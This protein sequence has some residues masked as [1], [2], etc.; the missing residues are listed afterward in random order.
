M[1]SFL[2]QISSS[3][4]IKIPV[5]LWDWLL[6]CL[7]GGILVYLL[8]QYYSEF[9]VVEKNPLNWL[10]YIFLTLICSSLF[11]VEIFPFNIHVFPN[12]AQGG[13]DFYFII[14][15]AIPWMATA[16]F[17]KRIL[18]ISLATL[19][20]LIFSGF[21]EH[22]IFYILLMISIALL[23]NHMMASNSTQF[24]RYNSHPLIML[25]LM[26][27]ITFPLFFGERFAEGSA[28]ELA[29]R[30]D[31]S[32]HTGWVFYISRISELF[33][34]GFFSEYLHR[35]QTS[36]RNIESKI[37][38]KSTTKTMFMHMLGLFYLTLFV[39]TILWNVTRVSSLSKWKT[40]MSN[41]IENINMAV[42]SVFTSNAVRIDQLP[43]DVVLG[44]GYIEQRE[45]VSPIFQPV[46]NLDAFYI[47][48]TQGEL[49]FAYPL[50]KE[51]DM[52]I[53]DGE[54]VAFQNSVQNDSIEGAFSTTLDGSAFDISIIYPVHG[55]SEDI[56]RVVI[57]RMD[58]KNNPTFLALATLLDTTQSNGVQTTF[59]NAMAN[60]R[61][62]WNPSA[63]GKNNVAVV[64]TPMGLENWGLEL[65]LDRSA[66]LEDFFQSF[67][68]FF[69]GTIV[70]VLLVGGYYLLRWIKLE[71][72][73]AVL[74]DR[75]SHD[76]AN[77]GH[78]SSREALPTSLQRF[79]TI[80]KEVFQRLDKRYQET[81][82]YLEL[83]GSY[84][85]PEL[86]KGMVEQA[87]QPFIQEDM[88][89]IKVTIENQFSS[90]S[91]R[92]YTATQ[93]EECQ[94]YDYL[95]EQILNVIEGQ[96][97]LVIGN[98]ARFHQLN[99][100][101]GKPFPQALIIS[102]FPMDAQR[103][104]VLWAAF[105]STQEFSQEFIH[106]F[107]GKLK[108][109]SH[110]LIEI[111]KLQQWL[112][113]KNILSQLFDELNFPLFIFV[114]QKLIYGN[115]AGEAFLKID[116][117]ES[118]TSIAKRVQ[119]NEIYNLLERNL[120]QA[121]AILTKNMPGGEKYEIEIFNNANPHIGQISVL[122][123]KDITQVKRREEMTRDF[124]TMLSHGLR[125]PITIMQGYSKM[126]PMVGELNPPQQDYLD[127]I[128]NGLEIITSLVE[129]ILLEDR[130]ENG[131]EISSE[132]VN[133]KQMIQAVINQLESF[134]TQKRVKVQVIDI[135]PGLTL[136]GDKILLNQAFSNLLH[137]AIK[138]SDMEGM[139][140]I[141]AVQE[142]DGTSITIKD[143]GPGIA[144]IDI[145]FI[146]EKYY[147]Q[148]GHGED[149][150]KT[151]GMGL[152]I[153]KFIIDAHR[154]NIS[155]ESELGKGTQFRI[156]F[157]NDSKPV[158]EN[159]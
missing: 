12:A 54:V 83:W 120:S 98:T 136:Q 40:R 92:T 20:G 114:D 22:S 3:F 61:V 29:V 93:V 53:S 99:R 45:M 34:A 137:N 132:E 119:E 28:R 1:D 49:L 17:G 72:A 100:A 138:F 79:L 18:S 104:A 96:S 14:L 155:V 10:F 135:D 31:N 158:E 64:Y 35:N 6:F 55:T 9:R 59:I 101:I 81:E 151:A 117:N 128:K 129:G 43:Q 21:Y 157:S 112:M 149:N 86:F 37:R 134:A 87:L 69:L 80:L 111:D 30:L 68:P 24:K 147:H 109:F 142:N 126:L 32:L 127:K 106:D 58:V 88:L 16:V 74:T 50:I 91:P 95:D 115:K 116:P 84:A 145:P 159:N 148:K 48:N 65:S 141:H 94:V 51:S 33:L 102:T 7:W 36:Q 146:F 143:S 67:L 11:R 56:T 41:S 144:S 121:H 76:G 19:G 150:N 38:G 133:I 78:P 23:F 130:I 103:K 153:S 97:Q 110:H 71:N 27:I 77:S 124:V 82:I 113:E 125:S 152:Y 73:I 131:E 122:L 15:Q 60:L 123:M 62:P 25:G 63:D 66:F 44:S 46:Q 105:R 8:F 39:L 90:R 47:F 156:Y 4:V 52:R 118:H 85:D 75:F 70:T 57:A 26:I 140:Q 139:V 2:Q 5:G 154:G 13:N 108:K 42:L 107:S 89:F